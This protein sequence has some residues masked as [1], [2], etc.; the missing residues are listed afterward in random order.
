M[1]DVNQKYSFDIFE[2]I[3]A[4]FSNEQKVPSSMSKKLRNTYPMGRNAIG[5]YIQFM[6]SR[7]KLKKDILPTKLLEKKKPS[8]REILL[9]RLFGEKEHLGYIKKKEIKD[10]R[11]KEIKIAAWYDALEMLDLYQSL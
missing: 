11:E 3:Y 1:N 9:T 5:E 8:E 7:N 10:E 2:A 6:E 4:Y